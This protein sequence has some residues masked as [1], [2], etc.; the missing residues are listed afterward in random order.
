MY[1][2]TYIADGTTT[3]FAF[4]FPFFQTADIHVAINDS[5][6]TSG[7]NYSVMPNADFSGGNIVFDIAPV[8]DTRI[9]IFRQISLSRTIDYQPTAQIDPEDLNSDFNF[10]LSAFQDLHSV[11]ID[12]SE[13]ANRHDNIKSL[14][15]YT[16][17]VISDKLSG[18]AVLGLYR[19]LVSV[20][21]NAL[22]KLIN[23]YG[24]I[25]EPAPNENRDDYGIL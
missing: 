7:I 1:K 25:T 12:L 19:N 14:I 3:E 10:L 6:N 15:D 16:H 9:D 4:R 2:I 20:L 13:W 22:P 18:G 8:A 17:S 5:T 11:N 23:D 24:H 21:E